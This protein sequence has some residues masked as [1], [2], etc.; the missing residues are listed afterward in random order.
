DVACCDVRDLGARD[1]D[2]GREVLLARADIEAELT[3]V[4]VLGGEAVDR[5]GHAAL[6]ADLLEES[7]GRRAAEDRVQDRDREPAPVGTGDAGRTDADVVLL[8][9]L[10]LEAH[11]RGRR[12]HER[13]AHVRRGR[14][15]L[16][17]R[18]SALDELDEWLLLDAPRGGDD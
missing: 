14:G 2:A 9:V 7:R 8:R 3:G 1:L 5:V 16:S 15:V 12:L 4:G 17:A 10:A 11:A 6:L 13:P 18:R